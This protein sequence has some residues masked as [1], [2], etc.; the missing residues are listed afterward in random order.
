MNYYIKKK[1]KIYKFNKKLKF[2]RILFFIKFINLYKNFNF[3]FLINQISSFFM[4]I[5]EFLTGKLE[6]FS[7]LGALQAVAAGDIE[8]RDRQ[9]I[10]EKLEF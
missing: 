2:Y 7:R 5:Y 1:V 4:I 6:N 10:F 3:K 9:G 8:S